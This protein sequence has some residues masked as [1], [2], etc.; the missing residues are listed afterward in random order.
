MTTIPCRLY[1]SECKRCGYK[2]ITRKA[3][4]PK[5]CPKCQTPYWNRPRKIKKNG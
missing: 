4:L 3:I 5:V 1:N 2:W